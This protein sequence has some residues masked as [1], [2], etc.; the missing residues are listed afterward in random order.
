MAII[1]AA[2]AGIPAIGFCIYGKIDALVENET[3][4][5]FTA[6]DI[7][8]LVATLRQ[9]AGDPTLLKKRGLNKYKRFEKNFA[10]EAV[11]DR[12]MQYISRLLAK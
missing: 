5:L 7:P 6:G 3:G 8:E 9:L 11:V 2:A 4:I 1:A 12:D 10:H